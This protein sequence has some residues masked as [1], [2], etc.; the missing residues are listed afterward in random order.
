MGIDAIKSLKANLADLTY[1]LFVIGKEFDL[2][3]Q[4]TEDKKVKDEL[5]QTIAALQ[6]SNNEVIKLY[7]EIKSNEAG[8]ENDWYNDESKIKC[9]QHEVESLK[10]SIDILLDGNRNFLNS[11]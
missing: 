10:K 8:I 5:H 1:I 7:H 3:N 2:M 9:L 11:K 4:K 6:D